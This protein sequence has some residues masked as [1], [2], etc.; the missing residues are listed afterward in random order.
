[1]ARQSRRISKSSF[2]PLSK[3]LLL[4]LLVVGVS[5][6]LTVR[7]AGVLGTSD[8]NSR[9][10]WVGGYL[11]KDLNSNANRDMEEPGFSGQQILLTQIGSKNQPVS[12]K[13]I[14]TD[15]NGYFQFKLK[16]E[17]NSSSYS[18]QAT[19]PSGYTNS[20]LIARKFNFG[21]KKLVEFGVTTLT[22]NSCNK[23]KVVKYVNPCGDYA[24][25]RYR[26]AKYTCNDGSKGVLGGN[27]SC[28]TSDQWS[29]S[30]N[31]ICIK[32]TG[33]CMPTPTPTPFLIITP[34]SEPLSPTPT[35]TV[36]PTDQPP[37]P[38]PT[39]GV[40]TPTATN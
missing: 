11:Y 29:A 5:G 38:T 27:T 21:E 22:V 35:I 9:Q 23:V 39:I 24:S 19:W 20:T 12:L 28:K 8:N 14:T 32:R 15:S 26:N 3:F 13:K 6:F 25:N 1:M 36:T 17:S 4:A 16:A 18:V 34:T 10:I 40:P 33:A 37:T 7:Q 30:A 31:E 2:S